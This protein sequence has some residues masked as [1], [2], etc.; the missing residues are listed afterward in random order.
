MLH[1]ALN[2]RTPTSL[3][4][5][6]RPATIVAATLAY[7]AIDGHHPRIVLRRQPWVVDIN[8]PWSAPVLNAVRDPVAFILWWRRISDMEQ[9][10]GPREGS[11]EETEKSRS[12]HIF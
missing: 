3:M 9:L 8:C 4:W 6:R 10:T 11:Q 7:R 1:V 2:P 12:L 5:A